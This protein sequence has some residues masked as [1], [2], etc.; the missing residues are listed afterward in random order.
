MPR[1]LVSAPGLATTCFHPGGGDGGGGSEGREGEEEE[2]GIGE[3]R[4]IKGGTGMVWC[5]GLGLECKV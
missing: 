3:G 2:E 5:K 1:R 4:R